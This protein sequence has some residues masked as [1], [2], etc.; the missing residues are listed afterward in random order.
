M[1]A[2]FSVERRQ[3]ARVPIHLEVEFRPAG[4]DVPFL[5]AT[6]RDASGLGMYLHTNTLPLPGT[7]LDIVFVL[8]PTGERLET[9]AV[10]VR[11]EQPPLV[12]S[13]GMA[14]RFSDPTLWPAK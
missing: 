1:N 3:A 12:S 6:S 9:T 2:R 8:P 5:R 14:V 4:S 10:V 7:A 13:P 11:T